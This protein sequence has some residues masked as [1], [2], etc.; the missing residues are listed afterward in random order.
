MT[1][2]E[3]DS[4]EFGSE[5]ILRYSSIGV[6]NIIFQLK[7]LAGWVFLQVEMKCE[8]KIIPNSTGTKC[9]IISQKC[10]SNKIA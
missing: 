5:R 7:R 1:G 6:Q 3:R 2:S 4:V 10:S 8:T 9:Q